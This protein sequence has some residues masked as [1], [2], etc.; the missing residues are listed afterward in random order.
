M[1]VEGLI[2][3][4][5]DSMTPYLGKGATSAMADALSLAEK[6]Q[7]SAENGHRSLDHVLHTYE[8]KMLADGFKMCHASMRIHRLVYC[9]GSNAFKAR[10]RDLLIMTVDWALHLDRGEVYRTGG[11][12]FILLLMIWVARMYYFFYL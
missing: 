10:C 1:N 12:F 8:E 3:L 4:T 6:L 7:H 9:W 2:N 5:L 11:A